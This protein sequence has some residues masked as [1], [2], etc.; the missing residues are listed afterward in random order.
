M[1]VLLSICMASAI[2]AIAAIIARANGKGALFPVL[3]FPVVLP[4][5]LL[6]VEGLSMALYGAPISEAL[7]TIVVLFSY[8]GIMIAVSSLL[9]EFIWN[10]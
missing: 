3:S 10:D 6:G 4:P 5:A 7:S 1:V 2:T 9:F 8:A